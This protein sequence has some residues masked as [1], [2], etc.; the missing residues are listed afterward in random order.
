MPKRSAKSQSPT[1]LSKDISKSLQQI[2]NCLGYIVVHTSEMKDKN[3]ADK[4][5]IF[6][7]LGFDRFHIASVLGTTPGTVSVRLSE[8]GLTKRRKN[9]EGTESTDD[10]DQSE[11][12]E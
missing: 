10:K 12:P 11:A 1:R 7:N 9:K 2:A 5:P 8:L 6:Y 4:I 3:D